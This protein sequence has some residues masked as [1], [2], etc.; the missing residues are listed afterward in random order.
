MCASIPWMRGRRW[1]ARWA[2]G[3]VVMALMFAQP[4]QAHLMVAQRG[5][6]N[7]VGDG[8]FVVLSLPVSAFSG[9]DDDGDGQLSAAEFTAHRAAMAATV[10]RELQLSDAQGP[11]RLEGVMLSPAS[12]DDAPSE[13]APQIV[14]LGRFQLTQASG[15]L[16]LQ[17]RLFGAAANEQT[18][19]IT[20]TWPA[21]RL[22]QQLVLTPQRPS[23]ALFPSRWAVFVERLGWQGPRAMTVLGALG[24]LLLLVPLLV[25]GA[26]AARGRGV[27]PAQQV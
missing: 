18:L 24:T 19:Q 21:Q 5:T 9:V 25:F 23:Q 22:R 14:V 2:S 20:A 7:I 1:P 26:R 6:L 10:A 4:I 13:P 8:A 3:A 12:P 16:R 17:T 11:R 27:G 15:S